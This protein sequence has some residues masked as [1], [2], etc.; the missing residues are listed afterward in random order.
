M[1]LLVALI[2]MGTHPLNAYAAVAI[3]T[4]ESGNTI[5]FGTYD[6]TA[7]SVTNDGGAFQFNDATWN[8]LVGTGSGDTATPLL[9]VKTFQ[10][11]YLHGTG[12]VHWSASQQCWSQW[13][14]QYGQPVNQAHYR[15]FV[16]EYLS[17]ALFK[18]A[19]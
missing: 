1:N 15:A 3:A 13:L 11:L 18:G 4:C 17:H 2:L 12:I 10:R 7:R 8:W 14:N 16:T 6:W 19:H 9:Q 5:D